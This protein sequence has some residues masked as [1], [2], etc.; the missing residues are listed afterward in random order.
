ME[1]VQRRAV[2]AGM[3]PALLHLLH[4]LNSPHAIQVSTVAVGADAQD[5][6]LASGSCLQ[7][8]QVADA[9]VLFVQ[10]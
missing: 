7:C 10:I 3:V 2:K 6:C 5:I 1:E 4:A 9:A 8:S